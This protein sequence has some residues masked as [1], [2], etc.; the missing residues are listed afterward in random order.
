MQ[1]ANAKTLRKPGYQT[2]GYAGQHR[3]DLRVQSNLQ[4]QCQLRYCDACLLLRLFA[5][6]AGRGA[7]G[8]KSG[9]HLF[10]AFFASLCALLAFFV[11]DLLSAE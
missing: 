7:V 4:A 11:E 1:A 5:F 9:L 8:G 3:A 10:A 2:R 6:G